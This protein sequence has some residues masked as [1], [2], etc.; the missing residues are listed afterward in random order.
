MIGELKGK[1]ITVGDAHAAAVTN[2][3]ML[4]IIGYTL[5]VWYQDSVLDAVNE[6]EGKNCIVMRDSEG[7][8]GVKIIDEGEE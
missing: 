1:T 3:R 2:D 7:L 6:N 8:L 5:G 4:R